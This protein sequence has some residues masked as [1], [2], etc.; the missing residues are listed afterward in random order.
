MSSVTC[1]E[2]CSRC[3]GVYTVDFDCRTYEE[4]GYCERCGISVSYYIVK[5]DDGE[6]VLDEKGELKYLY[7][8]AGGYG[9]IFTV[10]KNGEYI[11]D[12]L[13]ESSDLE[14]LKEEYLKSLENPDV[15]AD[16]SYFTYWDPEKKE[17]VVL[18]GEDPGTYEEYIAD[19]MREY[20]REC[21]LAND[22][23]HIVITEEDIDFE[24]FML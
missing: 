4:D 18:F 1:A 11:T 24:R 8:E 6:P 23:E 14:E 2:V 15:D 20:E 13:E 10:L 19:S 21:E 3:G 17:I 22:Q 16:C 12:S 7:E 5:N 9:R